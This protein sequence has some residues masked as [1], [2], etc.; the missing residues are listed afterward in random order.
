MTSRALLAKA[1][2]VWF[3]LVPLWLALVAALGEPS[4]D[5]GILWLG[6]ILLLSL[7][8]ALN[9]I[10]AFVWPSLRPAWACALLGSGASTIF[11]LALVWLFQQPTAVLQVAIWVG[12][13]LFVAAER[14]GC[15]A[16]AANAT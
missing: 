12:P 2:A 11:L 7:A 15:R 6:A 9:V 14:A 10:A 16:G 8:A 1:A 13:I 4:R 5:E 3:A